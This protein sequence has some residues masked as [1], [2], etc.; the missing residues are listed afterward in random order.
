MT[1]LLKMLTVLDNSTDFYHGD[2]Q[3]QLLLVKIKENLMLEMIDYVG[4]IIGFS[5]CY[6]EKNEYLRF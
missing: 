4:P 1:I 2:A 3:K 6:E 5:V